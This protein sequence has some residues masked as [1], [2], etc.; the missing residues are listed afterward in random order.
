VAARLSPG[1]PE[2]NYI[3][4][5][6]CGYRDV[7]SLRIASPWRY[8]SNMANLFQLGRLVVA[9][10]GDG[11]VCGEVLSELSA[12]DPA[13]GRA[14]V[15]YRFISSL[16]NGAF[17]RN[18]DIR[19][20]DH[21]IIVD[22]SGY[23]FLAG[24]NESA[25][26]IDVAQRKLRTHGLKAEVVRALDWNYL[27]RHEAA[28]KNFMYSLFDW[29]THL[30]QMAKGQSYI[31]ASS[32]EK[33]GRGIAILGWGGVGKTT[34]LL[35]LVLEDGWNYLSDDLGLIDDSGCLHRTPKRLQ[36]YAYNTA[37]QPVIHDALLSRR[38]LLDRMLW[39]YRRRRFGPK[40]VRRRVAAAELFGPDRIACS[41]PLS[42]LVYLERGD[43]Y[44]CE[45]VDPGKL[46]RRM[47][48]IVMAE[49]EP[50]G[51]LVRQARAAGVSFMIDP[52]KVEK[53][54][55]VILA[56]AFAEVEAVVVRVGD[57]PDPNRLTDM[58]R[59]QLE[60]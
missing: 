31:H 58:V 33:N 10:E 15:E 8:S 19:V 20:T 30:A 51:S 24:R 48:A 9:V 46:A 35:K 59:D 1:R 26:R 13:V 4:H 53:E 18:G 6:Q 43:S 42:R 40:K 49:I 25:L 34:S 39:E 50:Y 38:P 21:D 41:A 16:P 12:C 36:V 22:G 54:T 29:S 37:N 32:I 55:A 56:R 28:A 45:P 44:R 23:S 11:Q 47:A 3:A 14:D 52:G 17:R 2:R 60:A 57:S 5:V 27:Y 7:V